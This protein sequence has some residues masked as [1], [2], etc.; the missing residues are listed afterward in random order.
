MSYLL[1]S[2]TNFERGM[3]RLSSGDLKR[4]RDVLN[5]IARDPYSFKE[6]WGKF[7]GLRSARF[8]GHRIIYAIEGEKKQSHRRSTVAPAKPSKLTAATLV[9]V[10][11]LTA[12]M[13]PAKAISL[14]AGRAIRTLKLP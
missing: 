6:L 13:A 12:F 1:V 3:R 5:E 4:S 9:P 14:C 7:R 11:S 10:G 8:G 2:T